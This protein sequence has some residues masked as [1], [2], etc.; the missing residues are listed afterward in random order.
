MPVAPNTTSVP[1]SG[2]TLTTANGYDCYYQLGY[3]YNNWVSFDSVGRRLVYSYR[4]YTVPEGTQCP[5]DPNMVEFNSTA[6]RLYKIGSSA[7]MCTGGGIGFVS[8]GDCPL[9]AYS[10]A[11]VS[12]PGETSLLNKLKLFLVGLYKLFHR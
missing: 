9:R 11:D 5:Y 4:N 6:G 1:F 12:E 10:S 8:V 7:S 2:A 3:C